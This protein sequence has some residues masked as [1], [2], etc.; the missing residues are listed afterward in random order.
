V[1]SDFIV[2]YAVARQSFPLSDYRRVKDIGL[3]EAGVRENVSRVF[4]FVVRTMRD[5]EKLPGSDTFA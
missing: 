3:L 4:G 2:R 1:T 5:N